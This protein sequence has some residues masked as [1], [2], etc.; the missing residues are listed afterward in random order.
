MKNKTWGLVDSFFDKYDIVDHH[1]KSYNDFV[2]NRIQNIIDITEPIT[3]ENEKGEEE[4]KELYTYYFK[5]GEDTERAAYEAQGYEISEYR[6]KELSQKGV[7]ISTTVS[8][9]FCILLLA[10]FIYPTVWQIGIKDGNLVKFKHQEVDTLKGLKIGLFTIVPAL[11]FLI[12]LFAAQGITSKIPL[13]LYKLV[14]SSFYGLIELADGKGVTFGDL[15][16][17]NFVFML[18]IQFII[19]VITHIS[20]ILGYK[21][22]SIG[23]KLVFKKNKN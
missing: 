6:L 11:L 4:S 12:F 1:I 23:E 9:I 17:L 20:Y 8:Q 19:P 22:I 16:V 15:S 5:D 7:N 14:N 10:T 18:V 21:N 3:I 13:A 2:E